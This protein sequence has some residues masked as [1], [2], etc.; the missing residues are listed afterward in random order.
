MTSP[1]DEVLACVEGFGGRGETV[2][3]A[4]EAQL[5]REK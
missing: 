1:V 5:F 2:E 4:Q 3:T